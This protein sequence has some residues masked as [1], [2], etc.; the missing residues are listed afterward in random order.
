[1][2]TLLLP[3]GM[4]SQQ[5]FTQKIYS[6]FE[7]VTAISNVSNEY[8]KEYIRGSTYHLRTLCSTYFETVIAIY[9]Q[10]NRDLQYNR[11]LLQRLC[12]PESR[13][14]AIR[15]TYFSNRETVRNSMIRSKFELCMRTLGLV[16]NNYLLLTFK[17]VASAKVDE[18]FR[19]IIV[20]EGR[21][22]RRR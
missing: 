8:H 6:S 17:S 16:K 12:R 10:Y 14:N 15:S 5:C 18:Q 4:I 13:P 11:S 1:M 7:T 2:K 22:W 20:D 21:R 3:S 19:D 9:N